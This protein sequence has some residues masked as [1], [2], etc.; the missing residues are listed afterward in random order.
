MKLFAEEPLV[1]PT[2][3]P[4]ANLQYWTMYSEGL[5]SGGEVAAGRAASYFRRGRI[6]LKGKLMETLTYDIQCSFDLLGKDPNLSSK[7]KANTGDIA[8]WSAYGTYSVLPESDWLMVTVGT[9]LPH[10]S[11]ESVTSPWTTSSLDKSETSCYLRQFVTGKTNGICP[12]VNV[13]GMGGVGKSQLLYNIA[14]IT[15][16]ENTS[17]TSENWSPVFLGHVI[18]NVGDK[19]W[20]SYKYCLSGNS[21][22]KQKLMSV[23]F[24]ASTQGKTDIFESSVTYGADVLIYLNGLKLDGEYYLLNRKTLDDYLA[25]CLMVRA[26]FNFFI[27]K[28]WVLEPAIMLN[29]FTGDD[30]FQDASFYDGQDR[31]IDAGIN[32]ISAKRKLKLNLHYMNR[33]GSGT[34]NYRVG[35][36]GA[37]GDYINFG[38]QLMI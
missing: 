18:L 10:L 36:S 17:I 13:G 23:G 9:F 27:K 2:A 16:Q 31:I 35:S 7:G 20:S 6:G 11:R 8:L 25:S 37:Y 28:D 32:L 22:K 3:K 33:A 21:L 4:Y 15:R 29:Q 19:E 12:G 14:F 5:E 30:T 34:K 26:S 24:G 38:I 1:K